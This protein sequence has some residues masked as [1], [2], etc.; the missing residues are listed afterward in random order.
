MR[1]RRTTL[2]AGLILASVAGPAGQA[3][4]IAPP[5]NP[6]G[7]QG[8]LH[9]DFPTYVSRSESDSGNDSPPS[10]IA[11]QA[12]DVNGDGQADIAMA[13]SGSDP[14]W[15]TATWVTFSPAL[16]PWRGSVDGPDW[17]GLRIVGAGQTISGVDGVGD[18]NADGLGDVAVAGESGAWVVFGGPTTE[19]VDVSQ[20]GDRGFT[21]QG[22]T[23]C[24]T[25]D[26]GNLWT[27]VFSRTSS[28]LGV[29]DQDGDGR[30]DLALCDRD[31]IR[32]VPT[33]EQPAGAVVDVAAKK[34]PVSSL[35]LDESVSGLRMDTVGDTDRDGRA[36]VVLGYNEDYRHGRLLGTPLPPA[37]TTTTLD[38]AQ[39]S[40]RAFLLTADEAGLS[41]LTAIGD[42]DRDGRRDLAIG[43][44]GNEARRILAVVTPEAG[45]RASVGE[46]PASAAR[47]LEDRG[48]GVADVGDQDGDGVA[49]LGLADLV[50]L[51]ASGE[52]VSID[53]YLPGGCVPLHAWGGTV[54]LQLCRYEYNIV[55]ALPDR[56][57]D[58]KPELMAIHTDP[59]PSE[60][61]TTRA[62][63]RLDVFP[64]AVAPVAEGIDA[65]VQLPG[66]ALSFVGEFVTAPT[67]PVETLAALPTVSVTDA[68]GVAH[69]VTGALVDAG[70]AAS[71]RVN[72]VAQPKELG[73]AP[74][75]RYT[76]RMRLQ[77]GRGLTG[78]SNEGS[79]VYQ[80]A[81]AT[82]RA[83]RP[84]LRGKR[85]SGTRRGER[86][87]GT[88]FPD[89]LNGRGGS[90]VLLGLSGADRLAG[91]TGRDRIRGGPG[92]DRLTGGRGRDT[93]LA[94]DGTRDVV[95]CGPGRDVAVLDARDRAIGCERVTRRPRP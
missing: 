53:G 61:N 41:R 33:P 81:D 5:I 24:P 62:T 77:N 1:L 73:L 16:L 93:L 34:T 42:Q 75:R 46:L 88:R 45:T 57:G 44:E 54:N 12:G 9:V 66:G 89:V 68:A 31:A 79:F 27:G 52:G 72:V 85:L 28:I 56:N 92:A 37:G 32:M 76:Y 67:G 60:P 63:W 50:R 29:G 80:P 82:A 94:A 15:T 18:V 74:G 59:L 30:P 47:P 55:G 36:D 51:S 10:A 7:R 39:R 90:D 20:L 26:G 69:E 87:V 6:F 38:E 8:D 64:S 25:G 35:A 21:I 14:S 84:L 2:V 43:L 86:L 40:S 23:P 3:S 70:T 4:A 13:I 78:T 83:R 91:G 95:L 71:T 48:N 22:V 49:D 11:R 17:Q 19:T 58:G 65:P